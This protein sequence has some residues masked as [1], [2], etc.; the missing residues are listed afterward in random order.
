M[1][2]KGHRVI[3]FTE[4]ESPHEGK[5]IPEKGILLALVYNTQVSKKP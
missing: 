5:K 4:Y 1:K 2:L 3:F